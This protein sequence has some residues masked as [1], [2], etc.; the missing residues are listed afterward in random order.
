MKAEFPGITKSFYHFRLGGKVFIFAV[1]DVTVVDER[2]EIRAVPDAIGRIDINHLDL[3]P[4]ALLLQQGIHHEQ[5]IT[6]NQAVRPVVLMFVEIDCFPKRRVFLKQAKQRSLDKIL[7][8]LIAHGFSDRAWVNPLMNVERNRRDL[9][10]SS[11]CFSGPLKRR[12]EVGIVCVTLLARVPVCFRSNEP[13]GRV[14]DPLLFRVGIVLNFAL[15]LG[16][17]RCHLRCFPFHSFVRQLGF[18][19]CPLSSSRTS[20]GP[21]CG[22]SSCPGSLIAQALSVT[23]PLPPE[24]KDS[25]NTV[26]RVGGKGTVSPPMKPVTP[27]P[28]DSARLRHLFPPP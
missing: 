7:P 25:P 16:F 1:F 23:T 8:V 5:A 4:H 2:L 14:V 13:H 9:E 20:T 3:A 10:R 15:L 27:W 12:I 11:L 28:V 21:D 19:A 17:R 24:K 6:C 22:L 18:L 26:M